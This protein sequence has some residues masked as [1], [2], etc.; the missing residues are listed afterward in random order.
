MKR[1]VADHPRL[2]D[3]FYRVPKRPGVVGV[4]ANFVWHVHELMGT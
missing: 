4:A 3:P 2:R 1:Y